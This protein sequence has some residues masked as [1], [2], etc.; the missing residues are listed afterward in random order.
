MSTPPVVVAVDGSEGSL[1][2]LDWALAEAQLRTAPLRLVHVRPEAMWSRAVAPDDI[3]EPTEDQVLARVLGS[4]ADRP[5]LPA[6]DSRSLVGN[7]GALL[8]EEGRSAQLLVLGSRGRG[9]FASLLLGSN[10]MAAARDA[11]CP[12]VVV[13]R[14]G[15]KV[16]GAGPVPPGPRVVVGVSAEKPDDDVLSFAWA[17]AGRHAARLDVV[18]AYPWPGYVWGDISG[19]APTAED[20]EAAQAAV[21]DQL[22]EIL[23]G[24]RAA[25][26]E[27]D[28]VPRVLPGDAAGHLVTASQ[29][30]LLVVVGRHRRSLLHP[31]RLLGSVTHAVLLHAACPVA[32]VPT[33]GRTT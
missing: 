24:H 7:P 13:P 12:V 26:P 2:A 6:V 19:F 16:P 9:G 21:A 8:P 14:P 29:D 4:L 31:A 28:V 18:C 30:A 15:R 22:D 32:V 23:D 33:A 1:R 20:Q 17:E 27:V 25:H 10:G 11:P 3:T 5:H